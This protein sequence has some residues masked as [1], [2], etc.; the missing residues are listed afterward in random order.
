MRGMVCTAD[1]PGCWVE[2]VG[3][4]WEVGGCKSEGKVLVTYYGQ[5]LLTAT[6]TSCSSPMIEL[7]LRGG[8][9]KAMMVVSGTTVQASSRMRT[10]S[11]RRYLLRRLGLE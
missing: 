5:T 7:D 8:C 3:G 2:R 9:A 10:L 1:G 11:L 4:G 6:A